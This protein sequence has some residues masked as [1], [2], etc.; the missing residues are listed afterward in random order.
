MQTKMVIYFLLLASSIQAAAQ[1][2]ELKCFVSSKSGEEILLPKNEMQ[3]PQ[4]FP[5]LKGQ[6]FEKTV[7]LMNGATAT[8]NFTL[9]DKLGKTFDFRVKSNDNVH[10]TASLD[11]SDMFQYTNFAQG[12]AIQ[13]TKDY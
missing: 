12:I 1:T 13:C 2:N 8:L 9:R 6:S 10:I 7:E 11:D 4:G 3:T 5:H